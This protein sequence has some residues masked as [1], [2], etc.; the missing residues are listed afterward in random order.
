MKYIISESRLDSLIYDYLTSNYHPDYNWG[1]SLY[2]FYKEEIQRDGYYDFEIED[3]PAYSYV[4]KDIGT[5]KPKT[6]LIE[7][8]VWKELNKFFGDRWEPVFVKWFEDNS[9]LPVEQVIKYGEA[10]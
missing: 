5:W 1:P 8:E 6:L 7:P 10:G 3:W 2:D 9:N 4:G